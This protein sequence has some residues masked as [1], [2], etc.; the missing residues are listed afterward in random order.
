MM[1]FFNMTDLNLLFVLHFYV[2]FTLVMKCY[3]FYLLCRV[4]L[5]KSMF[6]VTAAGIYI[7]DYKKNNFFHSIMGYVKKTIVT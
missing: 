7:Y 6:S 5:L 1:M 2:W 4:F 3:L